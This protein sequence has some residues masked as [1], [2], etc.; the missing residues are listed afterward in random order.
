VA[1]IVVLSAMSTEENHRLSGL[2]ER[3]SGGG[4]TS[5]SLSLLAWLGQSASCQ[6]GL[7]L[8]LW[9]GGRGREISTEAWLEL[10]E[11]RVVAS[12]ERKVGKIYELVKNMS[13]A[14]GLW[15]PV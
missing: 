7:S 6:R 9:G 5:D 1:A 4:E 14:L 10:E 11:G 8:L 12:H 3:L 15:V 13:M 2:G